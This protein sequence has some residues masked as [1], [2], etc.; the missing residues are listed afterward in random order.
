MKKLYLSQTDKKIS[1]FLGGLGEYLEIDSTFLRLIFLF[2]LIFSGF[3]PG[4]IFYFIAT[5]V[6]SKEPTKKD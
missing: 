1:G 5:L 3:L 6:V 4:L 2:L